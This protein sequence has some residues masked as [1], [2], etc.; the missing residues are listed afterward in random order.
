MNSVALRVLIV[1][2]PTKPYGPRPRG[3]AGGKKVHTP[4]GTQTRN[5]QIRSLTR[6]SIAPTGLAAE[7]TQLTREPVTGEC[8][9]RGG[10]KKI[11]QVLPGL[12]PGSKDSESLVMTIT[13]QDLDVAPGASA[14]GDPH[15][16]WAL[17]GCGC[18]WRGHQGCIAQR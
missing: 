4:C 6:Y 13:L 17:N 2:R 8:A 16:G 1:G 7:Q 3:R 10:K 18:A 5:L 9:V 15:T 14:P 12:E 11:Y